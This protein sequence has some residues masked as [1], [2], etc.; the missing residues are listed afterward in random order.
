MFCATPDDYE[1]LDGTERAN[2]AKLSADLCLI[3]KSSTHYVRG[4]IEIPI[5]ETEKTGK[6]TVLTW[7]VWVLISGEDFEKIVSN[8]SNGETITVKGKLNN[9]LPVY[10]N[11]LGIDVELTTRSGGLRPLVI[12]KG[13]SPLK[14]DQSEGI[15]ISR[16][17]PFIEFTLQSA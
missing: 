10:K 14:K 1:E 4:L 7:G 16:L 9:V 3:E 17:E 5:K 8:W 13:E 15:P 2:R 11:S 6:D 12:L